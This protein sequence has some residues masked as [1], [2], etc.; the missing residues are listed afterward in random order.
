MNRQIVMM[1]L[2]PVLTASCVLPEKSMDSAASASSIQLLDPKHPTGSQ[3]GAI[4]FLGY[5]DVTREPKDESQEFDA[6]FLRF[7]KA[8]PVDIVMEA[9]AEPDPDICETSDKVKPI[10]IRDELEF[11]GYPFQ[12]V[13]AGDAVAVR[14]NN[15]R[16][17]SLSRTRLDDGPA[18]ETAVSG[19]GMRFAK[20]RLLDVFV[21]TEGLSVHVTGA[22]FPSFGPVEIPAVSK[23]AGFNF[24][25][26]D[27]VKSDSV[28]DWEAGSTPN[29][30]IQ[31]DAGGGG[32]AV[33]CAAADDGSFE[34]PE[35]VKQWLGDQSIPNPLAYR[36]AVNF[37]RDGETL[38]V[39]SQSTFY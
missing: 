19:L 38:F 36:E 35:S 26:L 31:I 18:Y 17:A 30:L 14:V 25:K 8:V 6:R 5:L 3:L 12:F 2:L 27:R 32:R 10:V 21:R 9:L 22:E 39:V 1:A 11:P 15:R 29:R 7:E 37:Y 24:D 23:V 16:Y 33:F 34:F 28:F 20:I 4:R 13:D